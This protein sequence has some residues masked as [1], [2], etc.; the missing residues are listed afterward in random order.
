MKLGPIFVI[1]P[2]NNNTIN[3]V[4]AWSL[5]NENLPY[6]LYP[7]LTRHK[8]S[9]AT[10]YYFF[11]FFFDKMG[12]YF[13][14][15]NSHVANSSVLLPCHQ[16]SNPNKKRVSALTLAI[17]G[18]SQRRHFSHPTFCKTQNY[19]GCRIFRLNLKFV[20][21][22]MRNGYLLIWLILGTFFFSKLLWSLIL[23]LPIV[24]KYVQKFQIFKGGLFL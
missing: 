9:H 6:S 7:K 13:Q 22:F 2:S 19:R 15:E 4:L 16:K 18:F 1:S 12:F 23:I 10:T 20:S 17:L 24:K 14:E 3:F 5:V 11:H 8:Q 21:L